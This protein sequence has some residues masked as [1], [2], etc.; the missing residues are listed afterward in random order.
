MRVWSYEWGDTHVFPAH[1]PLRGSAKSDHMRFVHSRGNLGLCLS[2]YILDYVHGASESS[3]TS[4]EM[5]G[6]DAAFRR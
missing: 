5:L 3:H 4:M 6:G 1:G 2:G